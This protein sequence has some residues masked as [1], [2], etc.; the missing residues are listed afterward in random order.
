MSSKSHETPAPAHAVMASNKTAHTRR[1][2]S[3]SS[4]ARLVSF[5]DIKPLS[6]FND[7]IVPKRRDASGRCAN[8]PSQENTPSRGLF[9]LQPSRAESRN[10]FSCGFVMLNMASTLA[11]SISPLLD[12]LLQNRGPKGRHSAPPANVE[13]RHSS[14]AA[15][16][17]GRHSS[18]AANV[19]G[20]SHSRTSDNRGEACAFR[21]P[22]ANS[23]RQAD[24]RRAPACT[25]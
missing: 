16:V 6:M 25:L 20:K 23:A 2:L 15:N 1:C 3:D 24:A 13:G 18:P 7:R 5:P 21:A 11:T 10:Q 19:E 14:P 9:G 17:E 4:R 8:V 12:A 22:P